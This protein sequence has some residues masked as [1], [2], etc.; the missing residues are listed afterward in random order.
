MPRDYDGLR[1]ASYLQHSV[2]RRAVN[3]AASLTS[4]DV[5]SYPPPPL[6]KLIDARDYGSSIRYR[7]GYPDARCRFGAENQCR[8][9]TRW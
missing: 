2:Y 4:T 3:V 9:S 6:L 8:S 5:S 7:P 1:L